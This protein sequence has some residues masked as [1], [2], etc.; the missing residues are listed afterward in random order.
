MLVFQYGSNVD[1]GRLNSPARLDGIAKLM[2]LAATVEEFELRFN[3][4]SVGQ[5]CGVA[6]LAHGGRT[7]Y[8]ALYEIPEERVV[9]NKGIV[10]LKTLDQIE[11]EGLIYHRKPI[12]ICCEGNN[13]EAVTY[14]ASAE[15][16]EQKTTMLYADHITTGLRSLEAPP[17][18]IEYVESCIRRSLA[19]P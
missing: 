16:P 13:Y 1:V 12:S 2:G 9:R 7:I 4:Y 3:V 15:T 14:L 17:E 19:L 11:G 10:G 18:Y 5:G 8:G 6:N